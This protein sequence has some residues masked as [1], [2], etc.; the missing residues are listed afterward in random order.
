[1][2]DPNQ[3]GSQP[4]L[5]SSH[6]ADSWATR[7]GFIGTLRNLMILTFQWYIWKFLFYGTILLLV[8]WLGI[9]SWSIKDIKEASTHLAS[10]GIE[11]VTDKIKSV[12]FKSTTLNKHPDLKGDFAKWFK[13]ETKAE[14]HDVY[15]YAEVEGREIFVMKD[16]WFRDG[17]PL[18]IEYSKIIGEDANT[19]CGMHGGFVA[20]EKEVEG[21]S[22]VHRPKEGFDNK[23]NDGWK[24][25]KM[26]RCVIDLGGAE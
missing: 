3:Y 14:M 13:E 7:S 17:K 25:E 15:Q 2:F 19:L 12:S 4:E 5:N 16:V 26:F 21:A 8:S 18:L 9:S 20:Q 23:S 11:P 1:M 24:G 22:V 6:E 10:G